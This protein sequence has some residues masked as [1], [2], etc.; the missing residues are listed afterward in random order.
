MP[1]DQSISDF[2]SHRAG[3]PELW[4]RLQRHQTDFCIAMELPHYYTSPSWLAARSVLDLGTGNGYYVHRIESRFPEKHYTGIDI[5]EELIDVAER[6]ND[7]SNIAFRCGDFF[8]LEQRF[9]FV[10]VRLVLQHLPDVDVALRKL[11]EITAP[12]GSALVIDAYDPVRF[13]WPDVP[14]FMRF[15]CAYADYQRELGLDRSA[16]DNLAETAKAH[17]TWRVG[18]ALHVTVPSTLPGNLDLF[19]TSY[20]VFIELVERGSNMSYDFEP[21]KREWRW[22]CGLAQAYTQAGLTI[23]RLDRV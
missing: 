21:V 4:D 6:E 9:D 10:I 15:F 22:W 11:A 5:C 2:T 14:N 17:D 7:K 12:G 20:G 3:L 19:R 1:H 8:D 16:V 23:V 18:E 13:Y